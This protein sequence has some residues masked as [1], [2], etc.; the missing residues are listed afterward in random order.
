M[1]VAGHKVMDKDNPP[2]L[3]IRHLGDRQVESRTFRRGYVKIL[4]RGNLFRI[5]NEGLG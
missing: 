4:Q 1:I 3:E 2:S 5:F